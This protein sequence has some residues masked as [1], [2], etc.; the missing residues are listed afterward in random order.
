MMFMISGFS[1]IEV[2]WIV[3][4]HKPTKSDFKKNLI[5]QIFWNVIVS[6]HTW[7]KPTFTQ[8]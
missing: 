5:C 4:F 2:E 1:L 6:E 7:W 8:K 3:I